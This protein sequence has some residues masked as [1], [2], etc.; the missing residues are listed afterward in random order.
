MSC[1][2]TFSRD[3]ELTHIDLCVSGPGFKFKEVIP[4]SLEGTTSGGWHKWG[5]GPWRFTGLITLSLKGLF[6]QWIMTLNSGRDV[7]EISP[8][9]FFW[10]KCSIFPSFGLY[11]T[12]RTVVHPIEENVRPSHFDFL[13]SLRILVMFV[14]IDCMNLNTYWNELVHEKWWFIIVDKVRT[15]GIL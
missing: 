14:T 9:P 3:Q 12:T 10:L 11:W 5:S 6:C 1:P 13:F 2:R 8:P 7:N 15:R 4:S